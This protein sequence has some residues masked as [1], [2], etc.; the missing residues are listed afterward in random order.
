MDSNAGARVGVLIVTTEQVAQH[1]VV[2]VLGE[3]IGIA[4][5]SLSPY[6]EGLKSVSDGS[7]VT[8]DVRRAILERS[9][10]EAVTEMAV[11]AAA[12]GAN[13]VVAMRFDHRQVTSM[14][15][16]I[17]AYG[18]AVLVVPQ[19]APMPHPVRRHAVGPA[20]SRG[21]LYGTPSRTPGELS[22]LPDVSLE[23]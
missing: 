9:R 14:W 16:E 19:A 22:Q 5:K 7:G 12:R 4:A 10:W 11:Q 18:T 2:A 6:V 1:E 23:E 15:N 3:V 13:A 17:C 20:N 8:D 21:S